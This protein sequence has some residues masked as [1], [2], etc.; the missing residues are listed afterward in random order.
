[1][2]IQAEEEDYTSHPLSIFTLY[3]LKRVN[4]T[5]ALNPRCYHHKGVRIAVP[6]N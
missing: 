1:M 2:D 4:R 3:K 6:H 5:V